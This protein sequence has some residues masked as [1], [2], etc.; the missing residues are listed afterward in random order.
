MRVGALSIASRRLC[1]LAIAARDGSRVLNLSCRIAERGLRTRYQ[2][3]SPTPV[4]ARSCTACSASYMIIAADREHGGGTPDRP[5]G[6]LRR[7]CAAR[8]DGRP[9]RE[10]AVAVFKPAGKETVH[11]LSR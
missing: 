7:E 8:A 11:H 10:L 5:C 6:R 1:S 3:V 2:V 4:E 9:G